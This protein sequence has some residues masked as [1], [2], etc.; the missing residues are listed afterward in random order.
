MAPMIRRSPTLRRFLVPVGAVLAVAAGLLVIAVLEGDLPEAVT[1]V[2]GLAQGVLGRYGVPGSFVL[3]YLE[4][5]GIPLPV[6]G[7]VY[8]AYLGRQTGG[9]LNR[10]L[11]A[12]LGIILVVVGGSSNL[13]WISRRW[14][15]RLVRSR[16]AAFVHL[17]PT[18]VAEA[19]QWFKRRGMVAIIFGRHVPGLRVPI[20][21]AAGISRVPYP[22]FVPSVAISTAIWAGVWLYLGSRFG[23]SVGTFFSGN[24]W[25]LALAAGVVIAVVAVVAVRGWRRMPA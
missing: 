7:D 21:V 2:R 4:E 3:L 11:A 5:S 24:A 12:W 16:L 10:W 17:D 23:P 13:Y 6:P 1:D 20:T 8:V 18:R 14:G 9:D 25:T 19:E 22:V 15:S